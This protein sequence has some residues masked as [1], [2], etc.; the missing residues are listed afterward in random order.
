MKR[1]A[2]RA[3]L[4]DQSVFRGDGRCITT[5]PETPIAPMKPMKLTDAQRWNLDVI[6]KVGGTVERDVRGFHLPGQRDTLPRM[7]VAA[8]RSLVKLGQSRKQ[9]T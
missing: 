6:C 5:G 7:N 1:R 8:V 9:S 3:Q 2:V 4:S